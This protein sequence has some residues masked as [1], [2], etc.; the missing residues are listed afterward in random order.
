MRETL[1]RDAAREFFVRR[2]RLAEARGHARSSVPSS[3]AARCR[4]SR[5]T[6]TSARCDRLHRQPRRRNGVGGP[7]T[8]SARRRLRCPSRRARRSWPTSSASAPRSGTRA[9]T[10]TRP[11][12]SGRPR[13]RGAA[14]RSSRTAP[15]RRSTR[16]TRRSGMSSSTS[17]A[18]TPAA[19]VVP[20]GNG[21]LLGGIGRAVKARSPETLRVGVVAAA[22]PVMADSWEARRA[23]QSEESATFADGLAVRIAIPYAVDVLNEVATDML[24]VSEAEIA[25]GVSPTQTPGSA[26][27]AR[28]AQPSPQCRSCPELDGP[29]VLAVT[30]RNID[31]DLLARLPGLLQK[32]GRSGHT[33]PCKWTRDNLKSS[34]NGARSSRATNRTPTCGRAAGRS[35]CSS[36]RSRSSPARRRPTS[37]RTS[38][39]SRSS[40]RDHRR[41]GGRAASAASAGWR[42]LWRSSAR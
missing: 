17:S 39:A 31:D 20:V 21:A 35:S 9:P 34:A 12:S 8:R 40:S 27:R 1:E 29:V 38:R 4:R 22:A 37:R 19:V 15:S 5:A 42:S 11:R 13:R 30:G 14:C 7:G 18:S 33:F 6:A 32:I 16:A 10:S 28:R 23:V 3:G 26:S 41:A 24:R 2:E 25:G 36:T